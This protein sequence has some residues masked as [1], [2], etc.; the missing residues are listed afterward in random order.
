MHLYLSALRLFILQRL[1]NKVRVRLWRP[2]KFKSPNR[3]RHRQRS[4]APPILPQNVKRRPLLFPDVRHRGILRQRPS[5]SVA[6]VYPYLYL[7]T[8][9]LYCT[10]SLVY[11]SFIHSFTPTTYSISLLQRY[12]KDERFSPSFLPQ[13]EAASLVTEMCPHFSL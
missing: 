6:P 8:P 13:S 4:P 7:Y 9:I 5:S 10:A 1:I 12:S 3:N 11:H 2:L